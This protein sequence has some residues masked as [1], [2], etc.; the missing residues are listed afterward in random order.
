MKIG[1]L[2]KLKGMAKT[3][4][5]ALAVIID[6]IKLLPYVDLPFSVPLEYILWSE[7][8]NEIF[9]WA[10]IAYNIGGDMLAGIGDIIPT[11]TICMLILTVT[12]NKKINLPGSV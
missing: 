1:L 12:K 5:L 2:D 10:N 11:N 8:K 6:I 3:N 7:Q 4:P 9:K